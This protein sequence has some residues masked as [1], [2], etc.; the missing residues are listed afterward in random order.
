MNRKKYYQFILVFALGVVFG[1]GTTMF[2]EVKEIHE[3]LKSQSSNLQL[4]KSID[5]TMIQR[6]VENNQKFY[7]TYLLWKKEDVCSCVKSLHDK[8]NLKSCKK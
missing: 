7:G 6:A 1:V 4:I 8:H 3:E 5:S 2:S